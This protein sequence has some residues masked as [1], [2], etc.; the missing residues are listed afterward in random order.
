KKLDAYLKRLFGNARIHVVPTKAES[1]DVFVGEE[2][3]GTLVLDEDEEDD[4]RSYNFEVKIT[5]GDASTTGPDIKQLDA[6]LKRKFDSERIRVVPRL[7]KKD[8]AEVY[9]GNEYIG[10]LFFDEKDTRSSFFALPIRALILDERGLLKKERG[11]RDG[12]G[13]GQPSPRPAGAARF[14]LTKSMY[15]PQARE[16]PIELVGNHAPIAQPIARE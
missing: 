12:G 7:R 11:N 8:S 5:L 14:D 15:W 16:Q 2:R 10:V 4:E 3:V 1:A 6:Y 13:G 9:V